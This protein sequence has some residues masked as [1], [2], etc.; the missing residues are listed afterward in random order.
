MV[1]R[2]KQQKQA[3]HVDDVRK[4]IRKKDTAAIRRHLSGLIVAGLLGAMVVS[5]GCSTV[6]PPTIEV[7]EPAFQG[8]DQNAGVVGWAE[9]GSVILTGQAVERYHRLLGAYGDQLT[10]RPATGMVGIRPEPNGTNW[11]MDAQRL[12]I[13]IRLVQIEREE[14]R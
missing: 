8:N 11:L 9:D 6:A 12:E 2:K 5:G 4:D 13:F 1:L 10:E 3:E 14:T 7:R